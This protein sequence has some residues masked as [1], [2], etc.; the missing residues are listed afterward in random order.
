MIEFL[1]YAFMQKAL[2]AGVVLGALLAY[3]G[4]FVTL[5]RMSFFGD[6]IAHASLAGIAI[7]LLTDLSPLMVAL[8]FAILIA[9]GIYVLEK[10][11]S[12][13]SDTIIGILFTGS[14]ALGVLLINFKSGYQPELLSFLFGNILAIQIFELWLIVALSAVIIIYLSVFFKKITLLTFDRETAY[15]SGINVGVMEISLYIA[16]AIAIVLGVKILGI[17]LVSALIITPASSAKLISGSFKNLVI[18]SIIL[19]EIT[20]VVGITVSYYFNL[21]TGAVIVLIGTFIFLLCL[22]FSKFAKK[23]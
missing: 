14:M 13:S 16:L 11:T 2:I 3:L 4:V 23:I 19:A 9:I 20:V 21:P 5:R 17:I 18:N 8:A 12:L 22:L 15:I 6:G 7:A 1:S 10:K